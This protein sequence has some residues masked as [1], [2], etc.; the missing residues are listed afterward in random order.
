MNG[1]GK[2]VA[3]GVA[4][5]MLV[6]CGRKLQKAEEADPPSGTY[7]A[8]LYEGYLGQSKSEYG[9]GDYRSSDL[10]AVRAMS[11]AEGND[12][13]P[14]PLDRWRLPDEHAEELSTARSRLVAAL[15]EGA[16]RK[17]PQQ[18]ASAQVNFDC[19]LQEQRSR[20][21]FQPDDIAACRD[22]FYTSLAALEKK[23]VATVKPEPKIA[24]LEFV[25]YFDLDSAK[26]DEKSKAVVFEA[27]AASRRL[28]G[29]KITV[30]GHTDTL[31][32]VQHNQMLSELR[33]GA[34]AKVL[35][36]DGYP[37]T[38]IE[39]EGFGQKVLAVP[40]ADQVYEPANRR[41]VIYVQPAE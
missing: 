41:A 23:P 32:S 13:G 4:A 5:V 35:T 24:P 11:A 10:W 36:D 37:A 18:A 39:T 21:N 16:A 17:M 14:E 1:L 30:G 9:E 8:S 19:W 34:V 38:Q 6:S 29:S 31:G 40:T 28:K 3:I 27:E 20:E 26:I 7:E 2:V 12:T 25:I 15:G 33:A 22:G